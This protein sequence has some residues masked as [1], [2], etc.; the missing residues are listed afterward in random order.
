MKALGCHG[1]L[2]AAESYVCC[3]CKRE[4]TVS[5]VSVGR[6]WAAMVSWVPVLLVGASVCTSVGFESMSAP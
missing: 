2:N 6:N 5:S 4:L 3:D 1:E